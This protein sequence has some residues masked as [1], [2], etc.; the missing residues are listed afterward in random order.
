MHN[1]VLKLILTLLME[2]ISQLIDRT[3]LHYQTVIESYFIMNINLAGWHNV[4][5]VV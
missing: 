3:V 4:A 1:S 5:I 2:T